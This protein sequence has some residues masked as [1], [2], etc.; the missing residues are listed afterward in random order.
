M[1]NHSKFSI[2]C[3]YLLLCCFTVSLSGCSAK[4]QDGR[5]MKKI[6]NVLQEQISDSAGRLHINKAQD[7]A[8]AS[9]LFAREMKCV[10]GGPVDTST[11]NSTWKNR[12]SVMD[13]D[14]WR[15]ELNAILFDPDEYP[16]GY[17]EKWYDQVLREALT[18]DE[19]K[20]MEDLR[21]K[22]GYWDELKKV[23]R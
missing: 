1:A 13:M 3:V 9:C 6:V 11:K 18:D 15:K 7:L 2:F 14:T 8:A 16:G 21:V 5:K 10:A 20:F 22:Y 4:A 19:M 23:L 17:T 12:D